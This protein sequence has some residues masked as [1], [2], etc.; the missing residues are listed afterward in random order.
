MHLFLS[1]G[2]SGHKTMYIHQATGYGA[3]AY[4]SLLML[5][6]REPVLFA[7]P[8]PRAVFLSF[9]GPL[10]PFKKGSGSIFFFNSQLEKG[11]QHLLHASGRRSYAGS[12]HGFT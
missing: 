3:A 10:K 9:Q 12:D 4:I 7:A 2:D 8:L 1:D 5:V 6:P 11:S